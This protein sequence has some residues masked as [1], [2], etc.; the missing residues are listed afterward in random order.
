MDLLPRTERVLKNCEPSLYNKRLCVRIWADFPRGPG[1]APGTSSFLST[2]LTV[3]ARRAIT[4]PILHHLFLSL[5]SLLTIW[6]VLPSHDAEHCTGPCSGAEGRGIALRKWRRVESLFAQHIHR[7]EKTKRQGK[8]KFYSEI[9]VWSTG[10]SISGKVRVCYPFATA[11]G[12]GLEPTHKYPWPIS[13]G[14]KWP[15]LISDN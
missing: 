4:P 15:E 6:R 9:T 10:D 8:Y 3:R 12:P 5:P 14:L 7:C 11:C 1:R 2:L 13:T